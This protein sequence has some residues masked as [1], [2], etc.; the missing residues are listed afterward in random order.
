[1][2]KPKIDKC[3]MWLEC[4]V[5]PQGYAEQC[6][7]S[8]I[9]DYLRATRK[10]KHRAL[11]AETTAADFAGSNTKLQIAVQEMAKALESCHG[12]ENDDGSEA[13]YFDEDAV[14]KALANYRKA[15]GQ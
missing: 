11:L 10:W 8:V 1:M 3:I 4:N 5:S 6:M 14:K 7:F 12:G 15:G 13:Q 9:C 2:I